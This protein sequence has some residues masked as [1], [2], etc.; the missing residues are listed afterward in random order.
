MCIAAPGKVTEIF[1]E[2]NLAMGRIDYGGVAKTACLEYVPEAQ[3]GDW[4]LVHAGFAIS[5]MDESEAA[6]FY[7]MWSEVE[8]L[9]PK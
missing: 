5:V 7:Q 3:I 1:K 8:K 9:T 6:E 2:N 4:V